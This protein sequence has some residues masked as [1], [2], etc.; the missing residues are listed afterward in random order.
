MAAHEDSTALQ[1][2]IRFRPLG[3]REVASGVAWTAMTEYS[4]VCETGEDNKP[5]KDSGATFD[6]VYG[7][8]ATTEQVYKDVG[9]A[10]VGNAMR[11]INGTVFAYGMTSSGKT[12][13]MQGDGKKNSSNVGFIE[14]AARQIFEHVENT[15]EREFLLRLSYVEIYNEVIRDL[16]QPDKKLGSHLKIHVNPRTGP[17]VNSTS[18]VVTDAESIMSA[19][20]R[21][22]QMRE[23]NAT[24]INFRS[25]RS[26][27]I[28][29]IMVESKERS[30]RRLSGD[31]DVDGAILESHLNL[32]DLAGSENVRHTGAEGTRLKEAGQ[33]NKSLL[34]LSRVIKQIGSGAGHI[35]FRD[36]KLTHILQPSLAGNC[37]TALIACATPASCF[38]EE[39]RT[40]L[41]FAQRAKLIKTSAKVN[42]TLDED[43]QLRRMK[44][45]LRDARRRQKQ[46]EEQLNAMQSGK[47]QEEIEALRDALQETKDLSKQQA[48]EKEAADKKYENLKKLVLTSVMNAGR[49]KRDAAAMNAKGKSRRR[50][51][52]LPSALLGIRG[53]DFTVRDEDDAAF[54]ALGLISSVAAASPSLK[55]A[56]LQKEAAAAADA[57]AEEERQGNRIKELEF[58]LD[59]LR[60]RLETQTKRHEESDEQ[61]AHLLTEAKDR[62]ASL[63]SDLEDQQAALATLK[64]QSAAKEV[65]LA[66]QV[67]RIQSENT[68]IASKLEETSEAKAALAAELELARAEAQEAN[69]KIKAADADIAAA[70]EAKAAELVADLE[71]AAE[72]T[73][74]AEAKA[75]EQ[76]AE[77]ERL[78]AVVEANEV[79]NAELM[80]TF[81]ETVGQLEES[82]VAQNALAEKYEAARKEI[83]ELQG[84]Q[85]CVVTCKICLVFDGHIREEVPLF[86]ISKLVRQD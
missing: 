61:Q 75:E 71:A 42:E 17:F 81:E 19:L 56:K 62:V 60:S 12:F 21:G 50:H 82:T 67:D 46:M 76:A 58:E 15:P 78:R 32:V 57:Q 40:T 83:S 24:D 80:A 25:S 69:A 54:D 84:S 73:R 63:E 66:E 43:C 20:R 74:A 13:T 35:N 47:T 27:T 29:K 53:S 7:G 11:G 10:L 39:T 85:V 1:V 41:A 38:R 49:R 77:I 51:S 6:K 16:L 48:D 70:V 31:D 34:T 9:S 18:V 30:E 14:L 72:A 28:F 55:K 44:K 5:I 33:I 37:K 4:T 23:V 8:E 64:E 65:V 59:V 2:C 79:T 68:D 52:M 22:D 26:H 45:D 3:E 86:T 36:S